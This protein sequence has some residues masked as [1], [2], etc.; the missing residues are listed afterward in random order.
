MDYFF[1]IVFEQQF[2]I[3]KI[4]VISKSQINLSPI[5]NFL[6][7]CDLISD[8]YENKKIYQIP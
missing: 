5:N 1:G 8:E 3:D 4:G 6:I 2:K 7:L